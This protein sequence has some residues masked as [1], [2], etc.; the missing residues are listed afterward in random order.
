M[1]ELSL[2]K[3]SKSVRIPMTRV[4]A[5]AWFLSTH[6]RYGGRGLLRKTPEGLE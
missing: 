2:N 1:N 3:T 4:M 6:C 5:Q